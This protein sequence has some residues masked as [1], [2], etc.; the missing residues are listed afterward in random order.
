MNNHKKEKESNNYMCKV[1]KSNEVITNIS[2]FAEIS[3]K[4]EKKR[5]YGKKKIV[6]KK[7]MC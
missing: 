3:E 7:E 5:Y 1:H 4:R 6:K 2:C